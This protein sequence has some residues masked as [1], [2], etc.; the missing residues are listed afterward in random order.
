[1]TDERKWIHPRLLQML[2]MIEYM[3]KTG[4]TYDQRSLDEYDRLR[5]E[6]GGGYADTKEDEIP[7]PIL[8]EEAKAVLG[9]VEEQLISGNCDECDYRN[10]DCR[11]N[12]NLGTT[13]MN[14]KRMPISL[15]CPFAPI[16]RAMKGEKP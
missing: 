4:H 12:L 13:I 5:A 1:M 9:A 7:Y 3:D 15:S 11:I 6:W 16:R 10:Q 8:T 14:G 2:R